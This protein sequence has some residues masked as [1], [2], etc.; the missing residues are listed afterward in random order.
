[1]VLHVFSFFTV[2]KHPNTIR[3]LM[4]M[5]SVYPMLVVF[6]VVLLFFFLLKR[7]KKAKPKMGLNLQKQLAQD[8]TRWRDELDADSER[9]TKMAFAVS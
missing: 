6:L 4:D 7:K 9:I 3:L 8:R 1:M 5:P 2:F